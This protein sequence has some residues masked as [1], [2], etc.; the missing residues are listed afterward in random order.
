MIGGFA[1]A[2]RRA[3]GTSPRS[4]GSR[5]CS[6]SRTSTSW[7]GRSAVGEPYPTRFCGPQMAAMQRLDYIA[8]A[9]R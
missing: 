3:A 4:T 6:N 8:K 5:R 2:L 1:D 9:M 7:P